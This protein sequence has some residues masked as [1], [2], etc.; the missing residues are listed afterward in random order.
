MSHLKE[1]SPSLWIVDDEPDFRTFVEVVAKDRGWTVREF[2]GGAQLV[3]E[4]ATSPPPD[5]IIL[6]MVMPEM[7]GIETIL[8]ISEFSRQPQIL[9]VSGRNIIYGTMA[10]HIGRKDDL[11][12]LATVTKPLSVQD[13]TDFFIS[14]E[15][16]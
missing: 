12:V 7:D 11:N 2:P 9:I 1:N 10:E 5:L 4:L 15:T 8:K 3:S 14:I 16:S 6:D 13:L